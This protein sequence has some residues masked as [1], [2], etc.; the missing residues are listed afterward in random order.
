MVKG[1]VAGGVAFEGF[2]HAPENGEYNF[3]LESDT[4]AML[5]LH[6]IRVIDEPMKDA[7]GKFS[8]SVR[9]KAGWHPLWL[10][11]RHEGGQKPKLELLCQK[12]G[13]ATLKLDEESCRQAAVKD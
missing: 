2:F 5:F 7:A 3:T 8:G 6:D 1:S 10:Y 13:G 4:G 12:P 9:L 11:Y